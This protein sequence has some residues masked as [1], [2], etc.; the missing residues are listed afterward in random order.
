MGFAKEA[1]KNCIASLSARSVLPEEVSGQ[2]IRRPGPFSRHRIAA[3]ALRDMEMA[4][5]RNRNS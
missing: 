4:C 2:V 5:A 1:G 3:R